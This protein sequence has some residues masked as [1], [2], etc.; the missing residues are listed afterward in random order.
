MNFCFLLQALDF[1]E[2]ELAKVWQ[3]FSVTA[4]ATECPRK[5]LLLMSL[6]LLIFYRLFIFCCCGGKLRGGCLCRVLLVGTFHPFHGW[7]GG[8]GRQ[9]FW[10]FCCRPG[11]RR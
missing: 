6:L 5:V 1:A 2:P 10:G 9:G 7:L 11:K 4:S 8:R 3:K